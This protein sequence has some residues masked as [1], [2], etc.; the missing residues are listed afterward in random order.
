MFCIDCFLSIWYWV[1]FITGCDHWPTKIYQRWR[2]LVTTKLF[3]GD[4]RTPP[5]YF[6]TTRHLNTREVWQLWQL[7]QFAAANDN[8]MD[9]LHI[10]L[11]SFWERRWALTGKPGTPDVKPLIH[12]DRCINKVETGKLGRVAA[13]MVETLPS[14]R[15]TLHSAQLL[16]TFHTIPAARRCVKW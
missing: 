10:I 8:G 14:L 6:F 16:W 9:Y 4:R 13:R 11:L 1:K 3:F 12:F 15:T 5:N 2:R 7:R